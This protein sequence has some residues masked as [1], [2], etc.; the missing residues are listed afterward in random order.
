[1]IMKPALRKGELQQIRLPYLR[2]DPLPVF[3]AT[4]VKDGSGKMELRRFGLIRQ[5]GS[6]YVFLCC[7]SSLVRVDDSI[8]CMSAHSQD[9]LKLYHWFA[10]GSV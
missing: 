1:M 4:E 8:D 6:E 10:Y 9:L 5:K 2:K 3:I 7:S